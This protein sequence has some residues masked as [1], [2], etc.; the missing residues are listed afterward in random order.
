[1]TDANGLASTAL[2]LPSSAGIAIVNAQ[3][4]GQFVQFGAQAVAAPA[5]SVPAMTATSQNPLVAGQA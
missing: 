5:L 3:A 4:I 1:V 2:H